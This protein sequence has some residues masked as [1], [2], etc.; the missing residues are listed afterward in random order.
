[1]D[2]PEKCLKCPF[3]IDGMEIIS[4]YE[5]LS[6]DFIRMSVGDELTDQA[7]IFVDVMRR[8]EPDIMPENLTPEYLA[9]QA[10]AT[11]GEMVRA[12][13]DRIADRGRELAMYALGCKG[14][15]TMR[16]TPDERRIYTVT[17]CTSPG[18]DNSTTESVVVKRTKL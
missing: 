14:P 4:R 8:I 7:N 16:A 11:G 13:E 17:V 15:L 3:V 5:E 9:N 18:H 2:I 6:D 10:R 12:I 1:M